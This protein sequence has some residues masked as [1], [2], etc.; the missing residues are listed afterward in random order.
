M[1]E[2][3]INPIESISDT[4]LAPSALLSAARFEGARF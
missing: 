2:S 3:S 1:L 4:C